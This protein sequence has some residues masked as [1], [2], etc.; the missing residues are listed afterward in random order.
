MGP[1]GRDGVLMSVI[2]GLL[3]FISARSRVGVCRGGSITGLF[4]GILTGAG[5]A[6]APTICG[7]SVGCCMCAVGVG[8]IG[9]AAGGCEM[10][11]GGG[12]VQG[13]MRVCRGD[14]PNCTGFLAAAGCCGCVCAPG[15]G[16]G[17]SLRLAISSSSL[18]GVGCGVGAVPGIEVFAD[19]GYAAISGGA[20]LYSMA[21][22]GLG[23][24]ACGH[25]CIGLSDS[26]G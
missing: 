12:G 25:S 24:G 9:R 7:R 10:G 13:L 14:Q 19:G 20:A 23:D 1:V 18:V 26:F 2:C 21:F 5:A 15:W 6:G 3:R 8:S 11:C 17:A 16:C 4:R 22:F